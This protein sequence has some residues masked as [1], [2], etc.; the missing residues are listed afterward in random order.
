MSARLS[1]EE[2]RE[3]LDEALHLFLVMAA[4]M[5]ILEEILQE[6][7]Y[8]FQNFSEGVGESFM[9][10]HRQTPCSSRCLTGDGTNN[11][12][13]LDGSRKSTPRRWLSVFSAGGKPSLV[14]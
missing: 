8:E 7:G 6:S 12:R 4:D 13:T 1:P 11:A 3:A 5:G 10:G 2:A 14:H 9:A